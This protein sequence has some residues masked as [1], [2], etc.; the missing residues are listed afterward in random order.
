MLEQVPVAPVTDVEP[1]SMSALEALHTESEIRLRRLHDDVVVGIHQAT[2]DC[3][4]PKLSGDPL[5][6]IDERDSVAVVLHDGA[7][8]VSLGDDVMDCAETL[9]ARHAAHAVRMRVVCLDY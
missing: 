1:T 4:P 8:A 9:L 6:T 3:G 5:K 2:G 7:T